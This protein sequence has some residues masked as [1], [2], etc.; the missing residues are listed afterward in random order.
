MARPSSA[1]RD[2]FKTFQVMFPIP[3]YAVKH[4][5][6]AQGATIKKLQEEFNV[7]LAFLG[8]N[9][10][11]F[12][13][14]TLQIS[15]FKGDIQGS[16]NV[17]AAREKVLEM[18]RE[19]SQNQRGGQ[20][21]EQSNYARRPQ[22][23]NNNFTSSRTKYEGALM[24]SD[25]LLQPMN[26][27]VSAICEDGFEVPSSIWP[28]VYGRSGNNLKDV[29]KWN[30]LLSLDMQELQIV[31]GK[32]VR[33]LLLRGRAEKVASAKKML[34]GL[35]NKYSQSGSFSNS[36]S[37]DGNNQPDT[38]RAYQRSQ[39]TGPYRT[40]ADSTTRN[41]F[42]R[43]E[44]P[45]ANGFARQ[46][47]PFTRPENG[48]GDS[49]TETDPDLATFKGSDK[50]T[51]LVDG[52]ASKIKAR[53]ASVAQ[54]VDEMEAEIKKEASRASAVDVEPLRKQIYERDQETE[55][56]AEEI[57]QLQAALEKVLTEKDELQN[58]VVKMQRAMDDIKGRSSGEACHE[59][60]KE[61]CDVVFMPCKHMTF[62]K[63]CADNLYPTDRSVQSKCPICRKR[64][65]CKL[66]VLPITSK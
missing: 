48:Q 53:Q 40:A 22:A 21:R 66:A 10:E 47:T 2:D 4:I 32:E 61:R 43:V 37:N 44:V 1:A 31:N 49:G 16:R 20:F 57:C 5:I 24:G 45:R 13:E 18:T 63:G 58:I 26:D 59:C 42:E 33:R 55:K 39:S 62:C 23:Q 38:R 15:A 51:L 41:G 27:D 19:F 9:T 54:L 12:T 7:R 17:E 8:E 34:Q 11:Q 28:E 50:I 35:V 36:F 46:H 29:K 56:Q 3:G 25:E 6:G 60:R 64:I 52:Y 65:E 14:R 30:D